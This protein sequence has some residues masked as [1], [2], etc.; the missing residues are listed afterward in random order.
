MRYLYTDKQEQDC[1]AIKG[2]SGVYGRPV[3]YG[4]EP[5]LFKKGWKINPNDVKPATKE[6]IPSMKDQ[7]IELGLPVVDDDGAAIH[8]KTLAK[9]IEAKR[10]DQRATGATD[11]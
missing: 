9:N 11:T 3:H 1:H 5:A 10:N 8:H 2:I 7:A 6:V 4:E